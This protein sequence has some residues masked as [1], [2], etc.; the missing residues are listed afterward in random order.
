MSGAQLR[1]HAIFDRTASVTALQELG[2]PFWFDANGDLLSAVPR[3]IES[4]QQAVLQW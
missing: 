2:R 1:R 4:L 3:F